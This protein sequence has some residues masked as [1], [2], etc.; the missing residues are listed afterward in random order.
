MSASSRLSSTRPTSASS[1]AEVLELLTQT[2]VDRVRVRWARAALELP[3]GTG[4]TTVAAAGI[5]LERLD[6][7]PVAVA[8]AHA[9]HAS[10]SACSSADP[11]AMAP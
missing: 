5:A 10:T 1:A 6:S 2:A 8:P 4:R 7:H 3:A 9:G 11:G